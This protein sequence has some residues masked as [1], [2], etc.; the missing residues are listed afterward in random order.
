MPNIELKLSVIEFL[1][2]ED[3]LDGVFGKHNPS[4]TERSWQ[5]LPGRIKG[6]FTD[7]NGSRVV[8]ACSLKGEAYSTT[9]QV[10]IRHPR[11][12]MFLE[13]CEKDLER[14]YAALI[15]QTTN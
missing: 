15:R 7:K 9:L 14:V 10:E 5:N 1:K 13:E 4:M 2:L 11:Y 12:Q 8:V 6:L 3:I